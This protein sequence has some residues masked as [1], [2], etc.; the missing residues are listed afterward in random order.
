MWLLEHLTRSG[1]SFTESTLMEGPVTVDREKGVIRGVKL[2]GLSSRNGRRYSENALAEAVGKYEGAKVNT[3]HPKGSAF[4][5]RDYQDRLGA[6]HN[7]QHRKGDGLYGDLHYNPKHPIAEQLA[8]D[9]E[10]AP[11]NVGLSH[12]VQGKTAKRG[13]EVVV[14]SIGRVQSVD[15]VADPATTSGLFEHECVTLAELLET[16]K[17][18]KSPLAAILEGFA[19]AAPQ[20]GQ[21]PMQPPPG[22]QP[23]M[24]GQ[25]GDQQLLAGLM[26]TLKAIVDAGTLTAQDVV[27][28]ISKAI[29]TAPGEEA[30][31]DD[32][33]NKPPGDKPP[34]DDED[35]GMFDDP[36]KKKKFEESVEAA[37]AAGLKPLTEQVASQATELA[38]LN[39]DSAVR[40]LLETF[41]TTPVAIGAERFKSLLES[42]NEEAMKKLV[43]SWPPAVRGAQRPAAQAGGMGPAKKV[44][45]LIH[46]RR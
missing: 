33:D 6:V 13:N 10:N 2:L 11:G 9:A 22:A 30:G 24:L 12:N 42:E 36:K 15:L 19:A 16:N 1:E 34:L 35:E 44:P 31:E 39:K 37:V 26:S 43:E 46:A 3:N 14:E 45:R 20:M 40:K 25:Q 5:P 38:S 28:I 8:W 18:S 7:V 4:T 27:R 41:N 29:G 17:D 32:P 23:G 21:A